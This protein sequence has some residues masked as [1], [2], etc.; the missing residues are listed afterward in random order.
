MNGHHKIQQNKLFKIG[1]IFNANKVYDRQIIE[2]IGHYTQSSRANWDIFLEEDW[3]ASLNNLD[4]W[5]VDGIIADFDNPDVVKAVLNRGIPCIGVG[6]SYVDTKQYPNAHYVGTDNEAVIQT[7]FD[8]LKHKGIQHFAFYGIE[9]SPYRKWAKEREYW[10]TKLCKRAGFSYSIFQS[11]ETHVENWNESMDKL[12]EWIV[13]LTHS[14]GIIAVTDAR[15]R[16]CLQACLNLDIAVPE[17]IS[18]V[19]VDDDEIARHLSRISLSSVTQGTVEMGFKASKMLYKVLTS[20]NPNATPVKYQRVLVK[21]EGIQQRGSTDFKALQDPYVIQAMFYIKQN[22][23]RGIKAQQVLDFVG[24]SR[25]N[26]ELRFEQEVGCSI[27]AKI[28]AEKLNQA[29]ELLETTDKPLSFIS[30]KAGYPSTQY[31][32][33][34]FKKHFNATPNQYRRGLDS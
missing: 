23:T 25:S 29:I 5:N 8:H 10:F 33:A 13:S 9:N 14:T 27:H 7:A 3:V 19:G 2:G 1:L 12:S 22:A 4:A 26:L 30:K 34:V 18:V 32:Y 21:P 16:H 11:G 24:I 31:M 15:A 20:K 28:H 6:S 17:A